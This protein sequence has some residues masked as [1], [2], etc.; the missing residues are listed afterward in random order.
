[1]GVVGGPTEPTGSVVWALAAVVTWVLTVTREA[2]GERWQLALAEHGP[3][4]SARFLHSAAFQTVFPFAV[5]RGSVSWSLGGVEAR[6]DARW[7]RGGSLFQE[8]RVEAGA[9]SSMGEVS[10]HGVLLFLC[11]TLDGVELDPLSL[12]VSETS[13]LGTQG[14]DIGDNPHIPKVE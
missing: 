8:V 11:F 14:V 13:I 1:M 12:Y 9:D 6:D 7:R 2:V 5:F 3:W 4:R 10:L